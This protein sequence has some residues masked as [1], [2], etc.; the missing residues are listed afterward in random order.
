MKGQAMTFAEA[1]LEAI[2]SADEEQ[3]EILE[4][5]AIDRLNAG[6]PVKQELNA[7]R[8]ALSAIWGE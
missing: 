4:G 6:Q 7:I 5:E 3:L 8:D 1:V 2:R